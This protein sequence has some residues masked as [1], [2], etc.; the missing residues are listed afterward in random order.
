MFCGYIWI[1]FRLLLHSLITILYSPYIRM[2]VVGLIPVR[3]C[4]LDHN[5]LM[6]GGHLIHNKY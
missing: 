2:D 1:T 4:L 5:L 6:Q 3:P